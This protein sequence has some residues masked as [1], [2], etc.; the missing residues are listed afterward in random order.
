[1]YIA[2]NNINIVF[3]RYTLLAVEHF[4]LVSRLLERTVF[5]TLGHVFPLH[6]NDLKIYEITLQKGQNSTEAVAATSV[7][8]MEAAGSPPAKKRPCQRKQE[9]A[10]AD[11]EGG[12]EVNRV[13]HIFRFLIFPC[14]K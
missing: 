9:T 1:M 14:E 11:V 12:Q 3:E 4:W 13:I 5:K 10:E 6:F 8:A 7:E 2:S